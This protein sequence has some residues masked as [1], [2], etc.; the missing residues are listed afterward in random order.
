MSA[1]RLF[2]LLILRPLLREPV[3]TGV[4][5]LAVALGVAVVLA[6]DLAGEAAT[7][8]F[9]SSLETL[10]G[11]ATLEVSAVGGVPE[12]VLTKLATYPE[13]LEVS[14]R[15][16]DFANVG[17]SGESV[18]LI[19]LDLVAV[20]LALPA[21]ES[22]KVTEWQGK[23]EPPVWVGPR[24][25]RPVGSLVTL[26]VADH[27][28]TA[29]VAGVLD[30]LGS[31]AG[32]N[33]VVMDIGDAQR[34]VGRLG[35][36]D[37]IEVTAPETK[38]YEEW[39]AELQRIMP[40]GVDVRPAGART[41]D[42][43]RMLAGFR[44]NVR[45]LSYIALVVGA[46]LIYN[47]IAVSVVRRRNEIGIVRAL[48]ASRRQVL[49][50]F[51]L[52]AA[53]LGLIGSALGLA[54]GR[55]LASGAVIM[56]GTTVDALYVSSTPGAIAFTPLAI[57]L[58]I[59][60]GLSMTLVA[61]WQPARDAAEVSPLEAMSRARQDYHLRRGSKRQLVW[62]AVCFVIAGL[63]WFP[64]PIG[65]TPFFGYLSAA[66]L[67]LA[68]ALATPQF[69]SLMTRPLRRSRATGW[70]P[71]VV[72]AIRRLAASLWRTSVLTAALATAVA[73]MVA[74]GIMVG[75]FRE[76]VVTWL[77]AQLT[78]EFYVRPAGKIAADRHPTLGVEIP[79]II[80]AVP[81][82]ADVDR[83]RLY[84]VPFRGGVIALAGGDAKVQRLHR[85]I[86]FLPG[87]GNKETLGLLVG[88]PDVVMVS[89][90]FARKYNLWRGDTIE[91]PLA[92]K[93]ARLRIEGVYYDYSSERGYVVMD[94]ATLLKYLP[95]ER[96]TNLAVY[97]QPGADVE[98][99]RNAIEQAV[100]GRSILV[101]PN[102]ELRREAITVFDRT[103]AIT[104]ALEAVAVAVAVIGIA[105]ALLALVIDSRRELAVLRF[106][107]GSIGQVRR[108]VL[109]QAGTLGLLANIIGTFMG[110]ALSLVL[111]YVIN[112]QSFGWTIKLHWPV[113]VLLAG[114]T[115]V[116]IATVLSG[117]YPARVATRLN[118]ITVIHEE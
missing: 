13:P 23:T 66:L 6:I 86:A 20:A 80:K 114:L 96:P 51:L 79:D 53:S 82:V 33:V 108:I 106:L 47:A 111:I 34:A 91:I 18:P 27:V 103:F 35:R 39:Q 44:W 50:A 64:P 93:T 118:P 90:P 41:E 71:D 24:L 74:V 116:Y 25:K 78:A 61:A 48:G 117:A 105:G 11:K 101:T 37:R 21:S 102:G 14:P 26:S 104:Y 69:I 7:G 81:G 3:R 70:R 2:Q 75:S 115:V 92:G 76:S 45:V 88:Q 99:V 38:G 68:F 36:V 40:T 63:C 16:E 32:D 29:R 60:G 100:A 8:S 62:S 28:V 42:S 57:F 5:V 56:L 77:D 19:G 67:I 97:L 22:P 85:S 109:L 49:T 10:A 54:L 59:A 9:R 72:I 65:R 84:D 110:V 17:G 87:Q 4:S 98:Q 1:Y 94:R 46:F 15:I 12:E 30:K 95:D 89:E 83:F 73:M 55:V 52:E 107:G 112:R 43:R 31:D 113:G 58:A